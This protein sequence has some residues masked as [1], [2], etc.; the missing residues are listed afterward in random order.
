MTFSYEN[1]YARHRDLL[2]S[3]YLRKTTSSQ[4]LLEQAE[5]SNGVKF[6]PF[7]LRHLLE[8]NYD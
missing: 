2:Q 4:Y 1:S 6:F 7:D 3:K 8:H 5:P